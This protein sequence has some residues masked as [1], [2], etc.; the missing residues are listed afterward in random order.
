MVVSGYTP[1]AGVYN[2]DGTDFA[3][4]ANEPLLTYS[5]GGHDVSFIRRNIPLSVYM[6]N[7]DGKTEKY[8]YRYERP[9][10]ILNTL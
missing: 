10:T 6:P 9:N 1:E 7:S 5:R 3:Y 8:F 2:F 4:K